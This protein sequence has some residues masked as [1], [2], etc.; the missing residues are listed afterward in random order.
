MQETKVNNKWSI[1]ILIFMILLAGLGVWGLVDATIVYPARGAAAAEWAEREYLAAAA[2]SGEMLRVD[3]ND[4]EGELERLE[5]QEDALRSQVAQQSP[6]SRGALTQIKR[7]EWLQSLRIINRLDP[8]FTTFDN[9][10]ERLELLSAAHANRNQ[11][12]PLAAFDIPMQW[13]FVAIGF[14]GALWLLYL[15]V[16]VS[17]RKYRY[18]PES[19]TLHLPCGKTITPEQIA[20][21]DKRKWDKF[22]VVLRLD[23]KSSHRLDLLRYTPLEEW[24][25]EMEKHSPGYEPPAED[26]AGDEGDTAPVG[27]ASD[28]ADHR[29]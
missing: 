23:D 6:G 14:G 7:M 21:V 3:V 11:P 1:K 2:D 19:H 20:Q 9:P 10:S 28:A 18:E 17:R 15:L 24:V 25:L 16:S 5:A 26:E 27:A 13:V 12:K 4:P 8:Q 29:D 22:I